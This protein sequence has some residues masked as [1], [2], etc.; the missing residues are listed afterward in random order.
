M[1][2]I[3]GCGFWSAIT[4]TRTV[5]FGGFSQGRGITNSGSS[6][7]ITRGVR[8]NYGR[9]EEFILDMLLLRPEP[10]VEK[11]E[12][13]GPNKPEAT[14]PPTAAQAATTTQNTAAETKRATTMATSATGAILKQRYKVQNFLHGAFHTNCIL[15]V[16]FNSFDQKIMLSY[17]C[18]GAGSLIEQFSGFLPVRTGLRITLLGLLLLLL[19]L[20]LGHDSKSSL[21]LIWE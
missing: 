7:H 18:G 3:Y 14:D 13:V 2:L 20:L 11:A 1:S 10:E 15:C 6:L 17:C 9:F 5:H 8:K 12:D 16:R 21:N 19:L 4:V